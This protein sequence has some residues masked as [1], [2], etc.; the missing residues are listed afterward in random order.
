MFVYVCMKSVYK[1]SLVKDDTVKS[2]VC[3]FWAVGFFYWFLCFKL[4]GH[5]T[6]AVPHVLRGL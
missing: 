3:C 1:I 2:V 4:L 6:L 5:L